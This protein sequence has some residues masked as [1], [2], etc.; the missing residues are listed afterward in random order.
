MNIKQELLQE[1]ENEKILCATAL[2]GNQHIK[3]RKYHTPEEHTAFFQNCD[4]SVNPSNDPEFGIVVWLCNGAWIT[5]S[6]V[7]DYEDYQLDYHGYP[8]IP[9][10]LL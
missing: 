8:T 7:G 3:L 4:I 9:K 5:Q 10:E 1:L 6:L 2:V